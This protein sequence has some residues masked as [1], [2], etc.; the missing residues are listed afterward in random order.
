MIDFKILENP[1]RVRIEFKSE[2]LNY[3]IDV[4]FVNMSGKILWKT[5]VDTPFYWVEG[6]SIKESNI[7]II[8]S[9]GDLIFSHNWE[10]NNLS[11]TVE[12]KF[13]NWCRD[14]ITKTSK[15]PNGFIIGTHDGKSGEWVEA[16][17]QNLIGDCVL[18]EPNIDPFLSLTNNYKNE[19]R[20]TFKKCVISESDDMVDFYTNSSGDSEA[21]S[22]IASNYLKHQDKIIEKIKVKSYN[23]NT[24]MLKKIPD[25]IHIDAEGY[26]GKIILLLNNEILNKAKFIIWEHIHLD[27][28]TNN[29]IN[30]KL[31]KHG[32]NIE[33]G[34]G[35]NT[36]AYKII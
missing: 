7:R 8:D 12:K 26:D 10:F 28:E 17:S 21:S 18:I 19:N 24:L 33:I 23:P 15:K 20:F 25:W 32:F 22:L 36:C 27:E 31:N 14:F 16:Y 2:D 3:P 1:Y 6:P 13:I 29:L 11:D 9:I 30:V 35:Y 5:S 4:F 34:D